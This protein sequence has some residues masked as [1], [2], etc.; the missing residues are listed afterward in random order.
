MSVDLA[1]IYAS[2]PLMRAVQLSI[3]TEHFITHDKIGQY[4]VERAHE[5]RIIALES[6]AEVD[7]EQTEAVRKLQN[8][9]KIPA[10]FLR[11]L[12]E[13]IANGEAAE[14]TIKLEEANERY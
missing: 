13:A 9:A 2:D 10:L 12:D 4:L 6:L 3:D 8:D 11:W 14:T 1:G 7:P 5:C